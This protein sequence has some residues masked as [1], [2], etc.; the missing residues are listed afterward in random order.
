MREHSRKPDEFYEMVDVLCIGRKLDFF[1][2]EPRPGWAQFGNDT[3]K[4]ER[5]ASGA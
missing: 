4:F 5:T 2:R 3:A 1:S